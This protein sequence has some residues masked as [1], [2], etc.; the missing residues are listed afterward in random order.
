M[1]ISYEKE[2][3]KLFAKGNQKKRLPG[4]ETKGCGCCSTH[5]PCTKENLEDAIKATE[6]W[7]NT[8]QQIEPIPIEE[9]DPRCLDFE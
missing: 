4:L 9:Y 6:D 8:L 7:L 3:H 2:S 5:I 1:I